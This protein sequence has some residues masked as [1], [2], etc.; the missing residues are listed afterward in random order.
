M[1]YIELPIDMSELKTVFDRAYTIA[2]SAHC[3]KL[4]CLTSFARQGTNKT[5]DDIWDMVYNGSWHNGT[6]IFRKGYYSLEPDHYEFCLDVVYQGVNYFIWI[7][8]L[9][10]DLQYVIKGD[11]SES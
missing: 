1:G 3:D 10:D 6:C 11:I 4:D 8:I 9:T 5:Y 2:Y 7:R